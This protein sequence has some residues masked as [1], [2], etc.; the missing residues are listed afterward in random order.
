MQPAQCDITLYRGD[1]FEMTVRLREG[2]WN[3]YQYV[4]GN[5][6]NLTGWTGRAE[7]RANQDATDVLASFTAEILT[8]AGS[9]LGGVKLSLPT[10][11]TSTLSVA[12]AVWDFQLTD[13]ASR[14][15]T[16]LRGSVAVEKDVTR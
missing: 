2:T 11:Q 13:P 3:G 1:Y 4:A 9:S 12:S 6:L 7:I 16:Y 14:V 8:Q 5:Y 15:Y 10:A